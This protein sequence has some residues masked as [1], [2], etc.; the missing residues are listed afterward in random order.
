V[1][2]FEFEETNQSIPDLS[3][4]LL[5]SWVVEGHKEMFLHELFGGLL[6]LEYS[7]Q[8]RGAEVFDNIPL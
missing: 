7:C 2:G 8:L 5:F 1:F 3:L 6:A 4:V